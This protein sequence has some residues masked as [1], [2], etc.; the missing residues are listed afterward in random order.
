ML[1]AVGA[2][3]FAVGIYLSATIGHAA[4]L[5]IGVSWSNLQE[6]RQK[7]EEAA[8]KAELQTHGNNYI[9]TDAQLSASKQLADIEALV[10]RGAN[11]LIIRA[12]DPNVIRPAIKWVM[13]QGIPVI[14]IDRPIE[15]ANVALVGYDPKEVGRI[16]ARAIYQA[17]PEGNYVFIK[18]PR[19]DRYADLLFA[20]QM[21][22]LREAIDSG[23][24]R[25]V[26]EA[27]TDG[28]LPDNAQKNMQQILAAN[29]NKIDAI[30]ASDDSLAGGVVAALEEQGLTDSVAVSGQGADPA[31]LRRIVL[32]TQ[33]ATVWMDEG[34]VGRVAANIA[35]RFVQ[36]ET[37]ERQVL[38][39]PSLITRNNLGQLPDR[40]VVEKSRLPVVDVCFASDRKPQTSG[41]K[42]T[43]SHE[44]NDELALGFAR[45]S[46]PKDKHE[47]GKRERPE[48]LRFIWIEYGRETEDPDKHFVL[49]NVELLDKNTFT[50]KS[51]SI[52]IKSKFYKN[53][54]IL[55]IHGFNV[56]FDDA[57]YTA[58]QIT[59]DIN[60]DGLPCI[61]SWPSK[62]EL[63]LTGYNYDM[64][65]A[66]QSRN[67][68]AYFMKLLSGIKE[69]DR[70]SIIAHSMGNL[71]LLEALRQMPPSTPTSRKPYSELILAAPDLD[72]D[73]FLSIVAG[74][75]KY[76]QGITLYAS[77]NDKALEAS[78]ALAASIPRAGDVPADGPLVISGIDT[79][80][81]SS[82]SDYMFGFNHNYFA[83]DRSVVADIGRLILNNER[84]PLSRN[85][86]FR[87]ITKSTGESYWK[88]PR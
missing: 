61:F 62:A 35:Y 79:I 67:R 19:D 2:L 83:T 10:A 52:L 7:A 4:G 47:F 53:Q 69:A 6:D 86:T 42:L 57:I 85:T 74:L 75:P 60:F 5:T 36:G 48:K 43:F 30:I 8:M 24:I 54:V 14:G 66:Q 70:I 31:A 81:A 38:L 63:S 59:W 87:V 11:V 49:K 28:W 17:K 29:D 72:R 34:K 27:Y 32:G 51:K 3:F 73:N 18:G 20:G 26:G 64:N 16:Q 46:I 1:R 45:V 44:R 76:A 33:I 84:P 22:V 71:A 39:D 40:G 68:L 56:S 12:Q 9:S 23:K 37:I 13:A 55:F 41:S 88:F 15:G 25:N 77:A 80:D 58:A 65:S 21:E 82:V 78:K 50:S